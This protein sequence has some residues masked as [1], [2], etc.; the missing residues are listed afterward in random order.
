MVENEHGTI[1]FYAPIITNALGL[2]CHGTPDEQI[3]PETMAKLR[4]LY[5]S[6]KAVG[7]GENQVRGL[8]YSV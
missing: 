5:P 2:Q 1:S 8:E 4:M 6:D 7:Y 3:Q